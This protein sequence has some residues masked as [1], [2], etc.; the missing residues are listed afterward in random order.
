MAHVPVTGGAGYIGS[1]AC[2]AVQ[3]VGYMPVTYDNL[4]TGWQNAVK[5]GPF[6]QGDLA[7]RG[8]LDRIFMQY[9]PTAVMHFAALNQVG[10]SI[11]APSIYWQSNVVG[12]LNPIESAVAND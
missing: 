11:R 2:K 10:G 8:N 3:Q 5:F 7:D 12:S 1:H 4:S 9:R 6:E